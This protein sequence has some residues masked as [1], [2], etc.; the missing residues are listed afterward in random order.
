MAAALADI[1]RK[2]GASEEAPTGCLPLVLW[3]M[4]DELGDLK[5]GWKYASNFEN[6]QVLCFCMQLLVQPR[7]HRTDR[8]SVV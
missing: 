7:Q 2:E 5:E 4:R 1:E 6:R 3:S 8:K